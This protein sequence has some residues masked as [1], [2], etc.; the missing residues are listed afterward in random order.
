MNAAPLLPISSK[1]W[2]YGSCVAALLG[3]PGPPW[4]VVRISRSFH[5]LSSEAMPDPYVPIDCGFHDRLEDAA[6]RAV[7]VRLVL[8]LDGADGPAEVTARVLDLWA[9]S[10][11]DWVKIEGLGRV[12]ADAVLALNGIERPGSSACGGPR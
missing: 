10:D 7:P 6:V 8:A 2:P 11:A 5:P 3:Q 9:E 1:R 4:F 12:R